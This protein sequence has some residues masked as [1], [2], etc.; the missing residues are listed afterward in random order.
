MID[1]LFGPVPDT[2]DLAR[3]IISK[4]MNAPFYRIRWQ[5]TPKGISFDVWHE[6]TLECDLAKAILKGSGI[7]SIYRKKN[8]DME[9]LYV[10]MSF[11]SMEYRI[12]RFFKELSG[13]SRPDED[14]PGARKAL[15]DGVKVSDDFYIKIMSLDDVPSMP[16]NG[17]YVLEKLDESI[18]FLLKAKYNTY[19]Q[20]Y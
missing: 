17:Y 3:K 7:Y 2:R 13:K 19:V 14:H 15:L 4:G 11:S 1:T 8:N 9:C 12:Y 16:E 6:D 20:K 18:A 5:M 10:G